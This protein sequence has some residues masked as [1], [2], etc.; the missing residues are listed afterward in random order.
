MAGPGPVRQHGE[1]HISAGSC[2]GPPAAQLW[3]L[4]RD[5]HRFLSSHAD[6]QGQEQGPARE[7]GVQRGRTWTQIKGSYNV[8]FSGVILITLILE[9]K[10]EECLGE[11]WTWSQR[12]ACHSTAVCLWVS[13]LDSLSISLSSFSIYW[14]WSRIH[15]NVELGIK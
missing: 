7:G 13:Y 8:W 1:S 2:E 6:G 5:F 10:H 9:H 15:L 3:H 4:L 11:T 12:P 14:G